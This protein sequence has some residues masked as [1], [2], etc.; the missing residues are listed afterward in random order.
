MEEQ[1]KTKKFFNAKKIISWGG[2]LLMIVSF[3]FIAQR[4]RDYGMDFSWLTSPTIVL[5][6]LAVAVGEGMAM[7][8]ASLNFRA[9]LK[10]V[11]GITV[12]RPLAMVVY[13]MS[14]LYKYIPGGVMYVAGRHKIVV[15][16][17]GL[18]HPK[19]IFATIFEGALFVIATVVVALTL[20]F[21]YSLSYLRV[22]I[23]DNSDF[24]P[25]LML[26]VGLVFL[27]V[28]IPIY[29]FRKKIGDKLKKFW[30][31]VEILKPSVIIK[32][33]SFALLIMFL[34]G[35]TFMLTLW[36]LGQPMSISLMSAII[37]LYLLS[38]LAG[39]LTP[40]AP[41][42]FGIREA[43]MMMFLTGLVYYDILLAALIVH[44]V[45]TMAGDIF[46]YLI[47]LGYSKIAKS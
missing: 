41:S 35:T 20:S 23:E 37:G 9:I 7:V 26:I 10:N 21:D 5:G 24:L 12:K 22:Q 46:G 17:K 18:T 40:G 44:R 2:S 4:F 30:E 27:A 16:T 39:F 25:I 8:A 3:I 1:N 13:L 32:R 11:S 45:V 42:G 28:I 47:G 33:F 43:V 31:S 34:W 29:I 38:W 19:M 36:F 14:N 15:E 6:L